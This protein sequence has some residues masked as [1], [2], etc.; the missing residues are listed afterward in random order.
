[1][2][3]HRAGAFSSEFTFPDNFSIPRFLF[4]PYLL[5]A[6]PAAVF[7]GQKENRKKL[8]SLRDSSG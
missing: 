7:A 1:M 2:P 5:F 8:R 4:I 6:K 3:L